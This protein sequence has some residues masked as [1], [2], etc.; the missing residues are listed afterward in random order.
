MSGDE[1]K[2]VTFKIT[3][4]A[5]WNLRKLTKK[6][7]VSQFQVV[8]ILLENV[9]GDEPQFKAAIEDVRDNWDK[10]RRDAR[11]RRQK[12][13][14]EVRKMSDKELEKILLAN[15]KSLSSSDD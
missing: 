12:L 2:S 8:T 14:S 15:G 5:Q 11:L 1:L 9:T 6:W 3:E 4:T 10:M 13:M 7:G